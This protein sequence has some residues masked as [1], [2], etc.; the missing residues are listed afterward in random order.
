MSQPNRVAIALSGLFLGVGVGGAIESLC[1]WLAW[2]ESFQSFG[3]RLVF[4]GWG[5]GAV[6]AFV[7]TWTF[8]RGVEETWRRAAL[9]VTSA[10]GAWGAGGLGF[11]ISMQSM[12]FMNPI[13]SQGLVPAYFV[14]AL[15]MAFV[16]YRIARKHRAAP[17][18]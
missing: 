13:V 5:V 3:D 4:V 10:F 17:T 15:V 2:R 11:W 9:A 18:A 16:S 7:L 14:A 12:M 8:S 1:T 6:S